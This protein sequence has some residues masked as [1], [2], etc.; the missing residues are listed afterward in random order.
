MLSDKLELWCP[1]KLCALV[2]VAHPVIRSSPKR[3]HL[4]I[5]D[6]QLFIVFSIRFLR[7]HG[8]SSP[9]RPLCLSKSPLRWLQ[10]PC[11]WTD[12]KL[13]LYLK[14]FS[15]N[16]TKLQVSQS[17]LCI[18]THIPWLDFLLTAC[19][20]ATPRFLYHGAIEDSRLRLQVSTDL[21]PA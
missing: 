14:S 17:R 4:A 9:R 19:E 1:A 11:A 5:I 12:L 16:S 7:L 18:I 3:L 13:N 8:P 15:S 6:I 2:H 10:I 21:C 20:K